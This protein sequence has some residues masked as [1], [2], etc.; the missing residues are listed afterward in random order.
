MGASP[1]PNLNYSEGS[2]VRRAYSASL[3]SQ[4]GCSHLEAFPGY[5]EIALMGAML[6]SSNTQAASPQALAA[7]V[8]QLELLREAQASWNVGRHC[9]YRKKG[10]IGWQTIWLAIQG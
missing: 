5:R 2:V 9:K 3:E 8:S 6:A 1:C 4:T 7:A 10:L